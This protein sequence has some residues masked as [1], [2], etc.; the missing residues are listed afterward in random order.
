MNITLLKNATLIDGT[1]NKSIEHGI[2]TI[3]DEKIIYVGKSDGWQPEDK[4]IVVTEI[5]LTGR[6]I[7]PGLIDCH[8]HIAA[9]C[10]PA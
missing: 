5:D 8:V 9:E 1:G 6:T 7:L 2:I 10:L 3:Q 4:N